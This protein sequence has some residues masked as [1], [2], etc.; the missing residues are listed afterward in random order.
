MYRPRYDL[1]EIIQKSRFGLSRPCRGRKR[2]RTRHFIETIIGARDDMPISGAYIHEVGFPTS[3]KASTASTTTV[4]TS[5]PHLPAM[6]SRPTSLF[7]LLTL[8]LTLLLRPTHAVKFDLYGDRYP[9]KSASKIPNPFPHPTASSSSPSLTG[10]RMVCRPNRMWMND[11]RADAGRA[12][13]GT[14]HHL[15]RWSLSLPMF[16]NQRVSESI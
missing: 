13:Y 8:S 12:V 2:W 11:T 3:V 9:K 16:Q 4:T 14:L 5:N 10:Y 15:T 1:A 6:L 7:I